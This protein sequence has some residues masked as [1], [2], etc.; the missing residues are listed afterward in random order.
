MISDVQI[1]PRSDDEL[2]RLHEDASLALRAN[3]HRLSNELAL[4]RDEKS[5]NAI[6]RALLLEFS[7]FT[8]ERTTFERRYDE[9]GR[10]EFLDEQAEEALELLEVTGFVRQAAEYGGQGIAPFERPDQP[11][12]LDERKKRIDLLL[13]KIAALQV[14]GSFLLG[15]S[16]D[17]LWR[18]AKARQALDFGGRIAAEDL[19]LLAQLPI[20]AVRNAISN[21]Q[22]RPDAAGTVPSAEA[23]AWLSRRREFC[24]SRWRNPADNQ[25]PFDPAE[26]VEN[27]RGM[28]WVP[29]SAEG[30]AFTPDRVVRPARST[31]GISIT[32]GAKGEERQYGDFY[33]ALTALASMRVARWRRRNSAGHWGIVRARGAWVAVSKEE[34]DQQ[35]AEKLA[36]VA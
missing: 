35:I 3:L 23:E 4:L 18:A 10:R 31:A 13:A 22:L 7:P 29:Q 16:F 36:E 19:G 5:A 11:S 32:I 14:E 20:T 17:H 34:I 1:I 28:V 21:G 30:D 24:P 8:H 33:D 15:T 2:G 25:W 9:I 26:I 12:S 27:E 6:M